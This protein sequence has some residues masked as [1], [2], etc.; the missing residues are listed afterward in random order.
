[1]TATR[2]A[3]SCAGARG[4]RYGELPD[5]IARRAPVWLAQRSVAEGAELKAGRVWR[6]EGFAVKLSGPSRALKDALRAS[7]AIRSADLHARLAPVRTPRPVLALEQRRGPFLAESLLVSEFVEGPSLAQAWDA[8]ARAAE[9]L[10]G[11]LAALHRQGVFH[12]DL[13]PMNLIWSRPEWVLIDVAALRHPLRRLRA[14][15]LVLEQWAQLLLRLAP[16]ERVRASFEAYLDE[17]ASGW[18]RDRAWATVV[19]RADSIWKRR[20]GVDD[21]LGPPHAPE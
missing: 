15:R 6:V 20:R 17:T 8:D 4:F 14:R 1:M 19:A 5:A 13:H 21:G 12:G 2:V 9:A 16:A 18:D 10:P 11:F 7:S 3:W